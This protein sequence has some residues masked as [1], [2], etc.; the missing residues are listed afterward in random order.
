MEERPP[1]LPPEEDTPFLKNPLVLAGM[2]LVIAL[3]IPAIALILLGS[4]GGGDSSS[5]RPP[6]T[7]TASDGSSDGDNG[8]SVAARILD[9]ADVR[10]GPGTQY[11]FLGTLRSGTPVEIVGRNDDAS[12]LQIVFPPNSRQRGWLQAAAVEV[13]GDIELVRVATPSPLDLPTVPT[14][15]ASA[16]V[17]VTEEPSET[18][19][20]EETP[21][22]EE[23]ETPEPDDGELPDLVIGVPVSVIGGQVVVT[24][25]NQGAGEYRGNITVSIYDETGAELLASSNSGIVAL[26]PGAGV[27]IAIDYVP[28]EAQDV[29]VVLTGD[30]EETDTDNNS[31]PVTLPAPD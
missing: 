31:A 2:G 17:S 28:T 18:V 27:D 12:W 11:P 30:Q 7:P 24:A 10:S 6:A 26:Q 13:E 16:T 20:A 4:D 29:I 25:I 5:E 15:E 1:F 3:L 9:V 19:E 22:P 14:S 21:T 8:P 23:D